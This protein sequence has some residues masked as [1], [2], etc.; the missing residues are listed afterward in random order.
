MNWHV[1]RVWSKFQQWTRPLYLEIQIKKGLSRYFPRE[2][3]THI[4]LSL[5]TLCSSNCIFCPVERGVSV[6]QKFMSLA[7]VEKIVRELKSSAF[8]RKHNVQIISIGENGDA[9]L[10]KEI[11]PILRLIHRELPHLKVICYTNFRTFTPDLIDI[12]LKEN[13]LNFVG[14]NID[15]ADG[16][17]YFSIKRT[18]F[19]KVMEHLNYFIARRRELRR[20]I[21]LGIGMLTLYAYVHSIYNNFGDL[22][23]KL[24][25]KKINLAEIRDDSEDVRKLILP[26]LDHP[27]D[28]LWVTQPVVGW[29]E[30]SLGLCQ[31]I[32]YAHLSCS[33]LAGC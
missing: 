8:R 19:K 29:A 23:L 12:V 6:R 27:K 3:L 32:D 13:L 11:L 21:P 14:C 18:D 9:F 30:R 5:A 10:N 33:S 15:S 16:E 31:K 24:K 26:L 4:N 1:T 25:D 17:T 28:K 22:P 7:L 20:D 2:S